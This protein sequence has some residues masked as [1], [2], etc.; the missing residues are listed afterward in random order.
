MAVRHFHDTM[1]AEGS[2]GVIGE[3]NIAPQ[4]QGVEPGTAEVADEEGERADQARV[5]ETKKEKK[6]TGG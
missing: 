3:A 5:K 2:A 6:E 1:S 4:L